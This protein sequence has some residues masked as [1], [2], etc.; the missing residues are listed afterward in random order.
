MASHDHEKGSR[1]SKSNQT[2]SN[3]RRVTEN[4][5][6]TQR[7]WIQTSSGHLTKVLKLSTVPSPPQPTGNQVLIRVDYAALNPAD[8]NFAKLL[9]TWLPWRRAPVP[10]LDFAGTIIAAGSK[11]PS[12]KRVGSKVCGCVSAWNVIKGNGSLTEIILLDS[13]LVAPTPSTLSDAEAA[14]L[15]CAGQTVAVMV[16][17]VQLKKGDRVLVN[18][19]SGG[20]GTFCVQIL[21]GL[22]CYVIA[23]C[24]A[25]NIEMVKKL[26]ADEVVD[27]KANTPVENYFEQTFKNEK[28]DYV[29]DTIWNQPLYRNSPSFLRE[30][31]VYLN[32]G[33]HGTD[34]EQMTRRFWNTCVPAWLGGVPRTWK[35]LGLLPKGE[36]QS[37]VCSWAEQRIIK[38]VQIDSELSFE[39]VRK[40]NKPIFQTLCH[41]KES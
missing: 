25:A 14:G 34:W 3:D 24:S 10:G 4:V 26:G 16:G 13:S 23:T 33:A 1:L 9:P 8:I 38:E 41:L 29:F 15:G 27:Y 5:A 31:G 17:S 6:N 30:G 40:V 7:A 19:G 18:G 32:I 36:L 37:Q 35:G 11:V 22:G 20:V 28:I 39:D 2:S 12:S 21:K